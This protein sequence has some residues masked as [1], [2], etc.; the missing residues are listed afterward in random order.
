M[1][2]NIYNSN[3]PFQRFLRFNNIC[4]MLYVYLVVTYVKSTINYLESILNLSNVIFYHLYIFN[5]IKTVAPIYIYIY[6]YVKAEAIS[7]VIEIR[8]SFFYFPILPCGL[9]Y[10][11]KRLPLW[12]KQQHLNHR[13]VS[14][15]S[16]TL[17][18]CFTYS[19]FSFLF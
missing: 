9:F 10:F 5:Q 2:S 17:D 7:T 16:M 3:N 8:P 18:H 15:G 19:F 6:Y 4:P 11:T 1:C 14:Q 12:H 13:C